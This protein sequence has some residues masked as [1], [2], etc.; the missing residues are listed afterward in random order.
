MFFS[1]LMGM[2]ARWANRH[3]YRVTL[4]G[5]IDFDHP[6]YQTGQMIWE[7]KRMNSSEGS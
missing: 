6:E 2:T 7:P 4:T 1:I 5:P 3:G